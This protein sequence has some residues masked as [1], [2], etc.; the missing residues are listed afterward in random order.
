MKRNLCN[1]VPQSRL[2]SK[3]FANNLFAK[4]SLPSLELFS[5]LPQIII[6]SCDFRSLIDLMVKTDSCISDQ[7]TD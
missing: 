4:I 5:C 1:K 2:G 3:I 7:I 6:K